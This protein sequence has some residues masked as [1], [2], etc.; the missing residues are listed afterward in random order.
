M[1]AGSGYVRSEAVVAILLQK[2]PEAKRI[3]ATVIHSKTNSDGY[4]D[5]G[6]SDKRLDFISYV[7]LVSSLAL[8]LSTT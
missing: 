7:T 8:L 3:Y 1:L 6:M 2:E 4:K 5:N